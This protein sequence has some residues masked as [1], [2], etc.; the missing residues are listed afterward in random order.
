[1]WVRCK[2]MGAHICWQ[3]DQEWASNYEGVEE[4]QSLFGLVCMAFGEVQAFAS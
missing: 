4:N 2:N 3:D 1:M